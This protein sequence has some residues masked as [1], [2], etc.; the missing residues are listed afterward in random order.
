M[1]KKRFYFGMKRG[2]PGNGLLNQVVYVFVFNISSFLFQKTRSSA[3]VTS[4]DTE[5][6]QYFFLNP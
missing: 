5:T 1:E 2:E 6:Q 4:K 3:L